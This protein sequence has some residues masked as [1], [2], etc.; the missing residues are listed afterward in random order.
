LDERRFNEVSVPST[1]GRRRWKKNRPP[2]FHVG[3]KPEDY[4]SSGAESSNS[5]GEDEAQSVIGSHDERSGNDAHVE[6]ESDGKSNAQEAPVLAPTKV[7]ARE[8]RGKRNL[9]QQ[10]GPQPELDI[11]FPAF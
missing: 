11:W 7:W 4:S 2:W 10:S 1:S 9:L 3:R 8:T 6:I 5:S